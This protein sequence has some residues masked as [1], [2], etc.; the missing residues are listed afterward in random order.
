[1]RPIV[2]YIRGSLRESADGMATGSNQIIVILY[3]FLCQ[4]CVYYL[5]LHHVPDQKYDRKVES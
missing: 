3:G 1:M 2:H 5:N 4:F